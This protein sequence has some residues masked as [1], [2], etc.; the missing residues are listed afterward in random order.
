MQFSVGANALAAE[1]SYVSKTIPSRP[2]HPVYAGVVVT[3]RDGQVSVHAMN[4]VT[5]WS[6]QSRVD[7]QVTE[8]GVVLVPGRLF[9]EIC[10]TVKGGQLEFSVEESKVRILAGKAKFTIPRM[11]MEEYPHGLPD[12]EG[13][14]GTVDT[15][16][17][18]DAVD[19]V[20]LAA[21]PG[22]SL[23]VLTGVHVEI[24]GSVI[25]LAATDRYRMA[26]IRIPWTTKVKQKVSL[27]IPAK[28][29][30]DAV[31]GLAKDGDTVALG[32]VGTEQI[33]LSGS[34]RSAKLGALGGE[35]P[36]VRALIPGSYEGTAKA[37][38]K[39]LLE[40]V[41]R[42]ALVGQTNDPVS[43]SFGSGST[44]ALG[45]GSQDAA[46][47]GDEAQVEYQG[48]EMR[49]LFN[50]HYLREGLAACGTSDVE[51]RFVSPAKPVV[52]SP[53]DNPSYTYLVM[54]IRPPAAGA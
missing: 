38:P 24:D 9:A 8:E 16:T 22:N 40:A 31:R 6:A 3:A 27:I 37:D 44:V 46:D 5:A 34:T 39:A 11:P 21:D 49:V 41:S 15:A 35:Y 29:L 51:M 19:K 43:L 18:V 23:P 26:T 25:T 42:V 30:T 14:T 32:L 54:T 48:P 36:A 2:T 1:V 53:V 13:V 20:A 45:C 33:V 10:S 52:L 7:A 17:L 50:P 28:Q 47:A 12:A 4:D